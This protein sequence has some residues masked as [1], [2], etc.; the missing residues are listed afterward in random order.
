MIRNFGDHS[1]NERTF[2]AWVRTSIAVIAFGFLVERFD[3]FIAFARAGLGKDKTA[4]PR[5]EF[6]QLAGLVLI[7][8]GIVMILVA[9]LRFARNAREIDSS[10]TFPGTGSRVDLALA[11]LIILLAGALLFYLGSTLSV[12][13]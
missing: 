10:K 1:A 11:V 9:A 4:A 2:L 12:N 8:L 7:I 6:G 3:L 5:G 13:A